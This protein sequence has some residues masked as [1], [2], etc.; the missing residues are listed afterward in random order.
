MSFAWLTGKI[1]EEEMEHE[2]PLELERIKEKQ[3]RHVVKETQEV[4]E[5]KN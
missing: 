3:Q 2:H 1:T 5:I 4:V